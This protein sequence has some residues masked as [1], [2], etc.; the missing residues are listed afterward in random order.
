MSELRLEMDTEKTLEEVRPLLESALEEASADWFGHTWDGDVLRL[1]GP[2][3]RGTVVVDDGRVR[4]RVRLSLPASLF[5]REIEKQLKKA[6]REVFADAN[7]ADSVADRGR[8]DGL[9]AGS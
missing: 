4:L 6:M 9:P 1:S 3:A 5:R 8:F 7:P 2:G